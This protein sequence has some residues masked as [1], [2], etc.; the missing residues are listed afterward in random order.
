MSS[1][2]GTDV[3]FSGWQIYPEN[4]PMTGKERF[5]YDLQEYNERLSTDSRRLFVSDERDT[6]LQVTEI[7]SQRMFLLEIFKRPRL[8]R[9]KQKG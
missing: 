2:N 8:I 1:S 3:A 7:G 4:L 9:T 5:A 6:L